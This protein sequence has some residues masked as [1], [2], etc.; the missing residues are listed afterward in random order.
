MFSG[1]ELQHPWSNPK[2]RE[3]KDFK[4]LVRGVCSI[5]HA[6]PRM[7]A[8]RHLQDQAAIKRRQ[9]SPIVGQLQKQRVEPLWSA[10]GIVESWP[11]TPSGLE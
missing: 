4:N 6:S 5:V 2:F 11:F 3:A 1:F 9:T 8:L 10:S 7:I